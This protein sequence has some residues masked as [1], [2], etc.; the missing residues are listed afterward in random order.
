MNMQELT[1]G[2]LMCKKAMTIDP[3]ATLEQ[4]ALRMGE[5]KV[6]SLIVEP[7]GANDAYAIITRKDIVDALA[8]NEGDPFAQRV[9]DVMSSPALTVSPE[10]SVYH[11]L[12]MM[13]MVGIRRLPVV[14]GGKLVG[15]LSNTDLFTHIVEE[16][17]AALPASSTVAS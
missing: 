14:D 10:L 2:D 9:E 15:V 6:S 13:K 12:R 5:L 16:L 17:A 8:W 7:R 1:A 11:C 4:A 3:K